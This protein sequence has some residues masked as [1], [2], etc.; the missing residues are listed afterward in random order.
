MVLLNNGT[1]SSCVHV[2]VNYCNQYMRYAMMQPKN[3]Q[4]MA[5]K[6]QEL[7]AQAHTDK[8]AERA[9][10][11]LLFNASL[12]SALSNVAQQQQQQQQ[13]QF[14]YLANNNRLQQ[15]Q[16]E[17]NWPPMHASYA[18]GAELDGARYDPTLDGVEPSISGRLAAYS[19]Q[20]TD[21]YGNS[22][23]AIDKREYIK[24]CSFNAVSCAKNPF[25]KLLMKWLRAPKHSKSPHN[26]HLVALSVWSGRLIANELTHDDDDRRWLWQRANT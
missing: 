12:R 23:S 20:A 19:Q 17:S 22:Q 26:N 15:Q 6:Q 9:L 3:K 11:K 14:D 2:R 18:D 10:L 25:R 4:S 13:Q 24:P 21:L 8:V 16:A 1:L 7:I 5:H